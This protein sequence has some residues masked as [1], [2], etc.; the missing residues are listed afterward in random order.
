M[1]VDHAHPWTAWPPLASAV[2]VC[3][4]L[5]PSFLPSV[6]WLCFAVLAVLPLC[7]AVGTEILVL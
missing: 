7:V 6:C 3:L 1:S 4:S 2:S 5:S